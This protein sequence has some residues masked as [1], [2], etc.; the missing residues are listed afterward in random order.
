MKNDDTE[1]NGKA[2]LEVNDV[3]KDNLCKVS[4]SVRLYRIFYQSNKTLTIHLSISEDLVREI[5]IQGKL[6][7]MPVTWTAVIYL[8]FKI[9]ST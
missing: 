1:C 6:I 4:G 9:D 8:I 3:Y 5:I 2:I 7:N